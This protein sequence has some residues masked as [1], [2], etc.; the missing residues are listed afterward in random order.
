MKQI[1]PRVIVLQLVARRFYAVP[2]IL[3][4]SGL[5]AQLFTGTFFR[6]VRW[7]NYLGRLLP[8]MKGTVI[9]KNFFKRT[10]ELPGNKVTSY[11]LLGLQF[12][13]ALRKKTT[14]KYYISKVYK[15]YLASF[16]KKAAPSKYFKK[17]NIVYSF[18]GASEIIFESAK[19]KGC[20]CVLDHMSAPIR[21]QSKIF[22]EEIEHWNGWQTGGMFYWDEAE[23]NT[24]ESREWELADAIIAPSE[25]IRNTLIDSGIDFEKIFVIPYGTSPKS[26]FTRERNFDGRRPLKLLFVGSVSLGKGVPY[27][28][29]A[30]KEIG[31]KIAHTRLVGKVMISGKKLAQYQDVIEL[32]G[33]IPHSEIVHQYQWADVFVFPSLCEGSAA[34]TYE[35]RANG[36]PM[37]VTTN[38]GANVKN[39]V[40]GYIVRIRNS[41]ALAEAI[42]KFIDNPPL[43]RK[44]SQAAI[45]NAKDYT[46]EEYQRR[47]TEFI[48]MLPQPKKRLRVRN[49]PGY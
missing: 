15:K 10:A 49:A 39:G 34:V 17:G 11:N 18:Y 42:K 46:W 25:F 38:S 1:K 41:T 3:N 5:L 27:L 22:K 32:V 28:L 47:L 4:R 44:M 37:I 33:P 29:E 8:F 31:P 12:R 35:A 6:Q 19:S 43:V 9:F 23:F 45:V 13:L 36:L 48:Y 21:V 26:Y 7:I 30:L 2:I 24:R 14:D 40:D 20:Y 16:Q